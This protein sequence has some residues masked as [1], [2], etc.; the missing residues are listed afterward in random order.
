MCSFY[1]TFLLISFIA[2][3]V[4]GS[5]SSD[6]ENEK[7][8]DDDQ[9]EAIGDGASDVVVVRR[10]NGEFES[11]GWYGQIGKMSSLTQSRMGKE[12]SIFVNSVP[13]RPKMIISESGNFQ[14][15]SDNGN[16][17]LAA[18]MEELNLQQGK[19]EARYVCQELDVII[20][21]SVFLFNET[22][23]LIISDIDGTITESDVKGHVAAFFGFTAVQKD[24][25]ELYEK[26]Y[27]NGY[28]VLYLT[29]RSM[30]QDI[31]TKEYLFKMLQNQDGFSIP[32]GPVLFSPLPLISGVIAEVV[33]KTPYVQKTK[34]IQELWSLFKSANN[35][36]IN[37]TI[38]GSYGDKVT[39]VRA[40][41][42]AGI[43]MMKTYIVNP[44]GEL[45]TEGSGEV[46]SYKEQIENLDK[47]YPKLALENE[48]K[49]DT[50]QKKKKKECN[51]M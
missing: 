11:T 8:C 3:E 16:L 25:V 10:M 19:N 17:M 27:N 31:S 9:V 18:D 46:S 28:K 43:S 24:V 1:R 32:E 20:H 12:V 7:N 22:D 38:V 41:N 39:D 33:E 44:K 15:S 26:I 5:S 36:D 40:Y 23:K 50:P 47:L 48:I 51:V 4:L 30:A 13:A 45:R 14:F 6:S 2:F 29:A 49:S 35:S 21:F 42:D 37:K 34:I